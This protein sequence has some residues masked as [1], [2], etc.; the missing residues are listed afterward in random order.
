MF[1]YFS[2]LGWP[3]QTL[4]NTIHRDG[5]FLVAKQ[6]KDYERVDKPFLWYY[7]FTHAEKK[8]FREGSHG[9]ASSCRKDVLRIMKALRENLQLTPLKSYY[10]KTI[11]LYECEDKPHAHQ[12]AFDQLAN[13]FQD[14]MKRLLQCLR[15]KSCPH[16]FMKEL[17][18]FKRMSS[19]NSQ[20]LAG[21]V[22]QILQNPSRYIVP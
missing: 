6:P 19:Q 15:Q 17:N 3:N 13:R 5:C 20:E 4:V 14:A 7:S 1:I 21:R 10:L 9:E 2:F 11:M 22:Q 18:L 8:L 12:W 16:Y